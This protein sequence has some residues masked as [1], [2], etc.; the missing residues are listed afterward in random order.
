MFYYF[1][2]NSERSQ[3]PIRKTYDDDDDDDDGGDGSCDDDHCQVF[4]VSRK[5]DMKLLKNHLS[6]TGHCILHVDYFEKSDGWTLVC[7]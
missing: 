5:K 4:A 2:R 3:G 7:M 1:I 6:A